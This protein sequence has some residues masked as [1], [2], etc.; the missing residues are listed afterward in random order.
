MLIPE[1]KRVSDLLNEFRQTS[2]HIAVVLDEYGGTAGIVTIEDIL[3]EIVGEIRDEFD[4]DEALSTAQ[5]LPDGTMIVDARTS[6][7]DI[8]EA[9]GADLPTNDDYD[10]VGGYIS[11]QAGRIPQAGEVVI[12][13]HLQAQIIEADPRR[14]LKA[15]VRVRS[16]TDGTGEPD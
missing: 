8:N 15:H 7:D 13:E 9:L 11:A 6:V 10:T 12:T 1:S 2:N 3:E 14:I 16:R 4:A 5:V